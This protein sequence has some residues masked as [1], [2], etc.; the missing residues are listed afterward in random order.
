MIQPPP[1]NANPGLRQAAV[2][3]VFWPVSLLLGTW[4]T[5]LGAGRPVDGDMATGH[6]IVAA[7]ALLPFAAM[8]VERVAPVFVA[9]YGSGET[10]FFQ[11][12]RTSLYLIGFA[13]LYQG[14]GWVLTKE[15]PSGWEMGAALSAGAVLSWYGFLRL[16]PWNPGKGGAANG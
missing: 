6:A 8:L 1:P 10:L 4:V 16:G 2:M 5:A 3:A 13:L 15:P 11:A 12:V 7:L 14:V 9:P